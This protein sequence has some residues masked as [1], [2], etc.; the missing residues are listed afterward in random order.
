MK[1]LLCFLMLLSGNVFS[2][3]FSQINQTPLLYHGSFAG[4]TGGG[5]L[6]WV[7][8]VSTYKASPQTYRSFN[9]YLS[10]DNLWKGIGYGASF[11]NNAAYGTD[12]FTMYYP[13][14]GISW[15]T[16]TLSKSIYG[17]SMYFS[18]KHVL[19]NA[20][21][22]KAKYT[23]SPSL[24][25]GY[26]QSSSKVENS[27][28]ENP[29]SITTNKTPHL[30]IGVL[31]NTRYGYIGASFKNEFRTIIQNYTYYSS[32]GMTAMPYVV[33]EESRN[34]SVIPSF[35]FVFAQKLSSREKN[36]I[37][38]LTPSGYIS[39]VSFYK[40]QENSQDHRIELGDYNLNLTATIWKLYVG[41]G[42][43][44]TLK[45]KLNLFGGFKN[46]RFRAGIGYSRGG[47]QAPDSF[48][49]LSFSYFFKQRSERK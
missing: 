2:Q 29:P 32:W 38:S 39:L 49:E 31:L 7:S 19:F 24:S 26:T 47:Y 25:F 46:D 35:S 30:T 9:T 5:R 43:T 21:T 12:P 22:D 33:Y 23:L 18:T 13:S 16:R 28:S 44:N 8:N 1:Q 17:G 6:A 3:G 4:A 42:T 27:P 14:P 40:R 37:F 34:S 15:A 20:S 10:Y 48:Y 36:E 11:L 45:T 41:I